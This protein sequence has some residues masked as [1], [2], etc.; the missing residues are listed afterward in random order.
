MRISTNFTGPEV[1]D[2]KVNSATSTPIPTRDKQ[3]PLINPVKPNA[4]K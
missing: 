3:T 1:T 2:S 4:I